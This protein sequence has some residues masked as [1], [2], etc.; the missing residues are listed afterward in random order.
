MHVPGHNAKFGRNRCNGGEM[1]KDQTNKGTHFS[2][3]REIIITI[4]VTITTIIIVIIIA[5]LYWRYNPVRV[6]V[7]VHQGSSEILVSGGFVTVNFFRGGIVS[8]TPNP[9]LGGP[10][11]TLRL[12]SIL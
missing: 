1:Y 11:T 7:L 12:V 8:P 10:G 5:I 6:S 4:I 3:Y 2:S 9:K